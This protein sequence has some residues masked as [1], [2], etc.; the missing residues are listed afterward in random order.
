M[1]GLR[2]ETLAPQYWLLL[3]LLAPVLYVA[4]KTE[5]AAGR[6]RK[7]TIA[8]L[9]ALGIILVTAALVRVRLW[10]S[11]DE[12]RLCTLALVDV[13]ESMPREKMNAVAKE[14]AELSKAAS[15]D[16]QFGMLLF[17]GT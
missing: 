13:S 17:A 15:E 14:I 9:R 16:R 6:T 1:A 8:V 11:A 4:L 5:A 10:R 12:S 2:I 3:C 7:I